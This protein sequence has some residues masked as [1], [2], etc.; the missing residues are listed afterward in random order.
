MGCTVYPQSNQSYEKWRNIQ[1]N[2]TRTHQNL[3]CLLFRETQI[4][5]YPNLQ[6]YLLLSVES[7]DREAGTTFKK[8]VLNS[9]FVCFQNLLMSWTMSN[10]DSQQIS[11]DRNGW[12]SNAFIKTRTRSMYIYI[13][14]V[15]Y[16]ISNITYIP[17]H[18]RTY[19]HLDLEHSID[20]SET[21]GIYW[22]THTIVK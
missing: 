15:Y 9:V 20:L 7:D 18:M 14:I 2:M 3:G 1:G 10:L 12:N 5:V 8:H 16:N 13:Y 19:I 17:T 4:K 6:A 11:M 21:W 22:Y